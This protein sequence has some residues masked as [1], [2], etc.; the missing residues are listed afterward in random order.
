MG[1]TESEKFYGWTPI[2]IY[3]RGKAPF[4]DWCYMGKER[5]TQPFFDLTI[6]Q[7]L[8]KPFNL[9][10]RHQTPLEF[11]GELYEQSPGLAPTGFIF[12]MSRCGSTL[13][14]QM[15][16]SIEKNIVI[17]EAPPID[18]VLRANIVSTSVTDEQRIEWLK[19][20]I[21]ALGKRRNSE[22]Y[23]FI[24]FDNWSTL[25]MDLILRAF[26]EVPWIFLYRN[27]VE[28]IVS[29]MRQR[30]AP[31]IPGALREMLPGMGLNDILQIPGEEYCARIL[32]RICRTAISCA[33]K[34]SALVINYDRLPEAVTSDIIGHFR[35]EF[36]PEE[37]ERMQRKAQF[38]AKERSFFF[39]PDGETKRKEA[40]EAAVRAAEKW[41]NPVYEKLEKM[42]V[43]L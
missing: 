5:F 20:I 17:S 26:P 23:Y 4:V 22:K 38:N 32:E 12:H 3:W 7:R 25:D 13:V 8:H 27:P 6:E 34:S 9:L 29:Q 24:K 2:R 39:T 41:A 21:G 18:S 28:V 1:I 35:A 11:L 16:A 31:M 37:I 14:A 36:T 43:S 19:W 42:S 15:L 30:G 33:H 10:F 40:S